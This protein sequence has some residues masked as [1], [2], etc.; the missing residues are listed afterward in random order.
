[1]SN[2]KGYWCRCEVGFEF[3]L[4]RIVLI[5]VVI[6]NGISLDRSGESNKNNQKSIK[7]E[8]VNNKQTVHNQFQ[9]AQNNLFRI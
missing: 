4:L 5:E 2:L 7:I 1:M 6:T 9:E 3:Q 8:R